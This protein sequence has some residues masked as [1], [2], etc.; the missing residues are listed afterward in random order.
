MNSLNQVDF[1]SSYFHALSEEHIE[2]VILHSYD[3]YP[4]EIHSDVDYCVKDENLKKTIAHLFDFCR[5]NGWR[6]IQVLQHEVTA[7]FCV[8]VCCDNPEDYIQLDVCSH[9]I[10][11]GKLMIKDQVLLTGRHQFPGGEFFVPDHKA[12]LAYMLWKAAAKNKPLES[13]RERVDM[14]LNENGEEHAQNN[15]SKVVCMLGLSESFDTSSAALNELSDKYSRLPMLTRR[16]QL[17]RVLRRLR[18]PAGAYCMVKDEKVL[19]SCGPAL[20]KLSEVAFRGFA[21]TSKPKLSDYLSIIRSTLLVSAK[22]C[23]VIRQAISRW[24]QCEFSINA[25][26]EHE[27]L[28]ELHELMEKRVARQSGFPL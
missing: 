28:R 25:S 19:A 2:Y 10:R 11:R 24:I 13:I 17:L 5:K 26:E 7:F 14:L 6:M 1:F 22:R 16:G 23:G 27:F 15:L 3:K 4:Q 21:V 20:Q 9:Y 12:E 18:Y 8:C